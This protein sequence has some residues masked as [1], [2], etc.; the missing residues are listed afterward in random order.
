MLVQIK[1]NLLTSR[2]QYYQALADDDANAHGMAVARM[3]VAESAAKEA[4][5]IAN[6]FP[7]SVPPSSNLSA[8]CGPMLAELAKRQVSTVQAKLKEMARD[9]DYVYHQDVPAEASVPPVA[10]LPA[11]KPIPVNEL[12]AGQD[13]Q[14]I[15]GPDLFAKIVPLAV[16]EAASLYDEEKAKLVRAETER[17]ELANSEMATSLDYL[18]LPGALQVLKGGFHHEVTPDE[19]FRTWCED[20][21]GHENPMAIFE[22]LRAEKE[23]IVTVLDRSTKQLDMEESVCEKMR[24]KY[25]G[26]WTQQ[27]SAKLTTT[28][29]SD[30]R[31]Y[32]DALDEASRSD[33]QLYAKLK[34]NEPEFHEMRAASEMGDPDGLFQRAI[35]KVRAKSS[36]ANSPATGEQNLLDADF[37]D[38]G[39]SVMDQINKVEDILKKLNLIKRVRNQVLKDLKDK[40]WA[41]PAAIPAPPRPFV[42]DANGR[43][44][45]TTTTSLRS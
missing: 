6:N 3:K 19:D 22:H 9:N 12:Y 7:G 41:A 2:A 15:T 44:R 45:F 5:R 13:I 23:T 33:G 29:R 14:R 25:E 32:R 37:D 18:R 40:V 24:S 39:P 30:V 17:V 26:E 36:S 38:G 11:A 31:S 34:Q 8:D 1:Y 16:T 42:E 28:L 4:S 27:P 35:A 21:A 20:V 43:C 10:K